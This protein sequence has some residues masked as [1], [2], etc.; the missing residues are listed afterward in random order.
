MRG[1]RWRKGKMNIVSRSNVKTTC[2]MI[3]E[4]VEEELIENIVCNSLPTRFKFNDK[5]VHYF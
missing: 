2:F 3:F 4:R 1:D 5:T